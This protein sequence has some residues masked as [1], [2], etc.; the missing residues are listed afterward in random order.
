MKKIITIILTMITTFVI[1]IGMAQADYQITKYQQHITI[2]ED[3]SALIEKEVHYHFDKQMNG[4]YLNETLKGA[5]DQKRNYTWGGLKAITISDNG[6][7]FKS[8]PPMEK[9]A[10]IGYVE[11]QH[12][13]EVQEKVYYPIKADKQ[14]VVK[15][16]YQINNLVVNWD[17]VSELNWLVIT[18]WDV[19]LHDV[20]VTMSLPHQPSQ[21][22]K[23]WVHNDKGIQG[24]VAINKAKSQLTVTTDE[25]ARHKRLELRSYFDKMQTPRNQNSQSGQRAKVISNQEAAKTIKAY[26]ALQRV[27]LFGLVVLPMV[28]LL[29]LLAMLGFMYHVRR[30]IKQG[31]QASGASQPPVHVYDIPNDLGPAIINARIDYKADVSKVIVATLL[32]LVAKH[33]ITIAYTQVTDVSHAVYKVI[34]EDGLQNY[35][36]TFIR[37]IFGPSRDNVFQSEFKRQDSAVSD[38]IRKGVG[39]FTQQIRNHDET[40]ALI[41][42]KRTDYY[43][44]LKISLNGLIGFSG[45]IIFIANILMAN[46]SGIWQIWLA[47]VFELIISIAMFGIVYY[48]NTTVYSVP[49]GFSEKWAWDGFRLM[50]HDIANLKDKTVLDVQLWDK[51]LAYAV[52]F[53]EAKKVSQT[54]K[55]WAQDENVVVPNLPLYMV[56]SSFGVDWADNLAQNIQ[57]NSAFESNVSGDGGSFSG[58]GF[59][60]GG[61]GGGGAF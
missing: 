55:L 43:N 38:R 61:G 31:K 17:D 36:R 27:K 23:A 54:L 42:Q 48:Q 39:L 28:T 53:G 8:V 22:L 20:K 58:G 14:L 10:V 13:D 60:G 21:T 41:N 25:V 3:G 1:G 44:N 47:A 45:F 6:G 57:T 59:S 30:A 18:N 51:L 5:A 4:I 49:D 56:Y 9:S 34:N 37:M 24:R 7:P 12:Q 29:L 52:I 26:R 46:Y 50:L 32:D 19:A 2:N 16:L 35:E 33:K 15:Y 40:K 11:T